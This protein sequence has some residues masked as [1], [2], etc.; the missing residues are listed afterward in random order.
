MVAVSKAEARRRKRELAQKMPEL[1]PTKQKKKRGRARMGELDPRALNLGN[2]ARMAGKDPKSRRD[3][4]DMAH[5]SY[6]TEAG[7][8]IR[9]VIKDQQEAIKAAEAYTGM[10][11]A[12]ER[13]MTRVIGAVPHAKGSKHEM[14]P[15]VLETMPGDSNDLRTAEEKDEAA[16]AAWMMWDAHIQSLSGVDRAAIGL[17]QSGKKLMDQGK[18]T[19][20]GHTFA[21]AAQA[22]AR[23]MEENA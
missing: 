22:L 3:R 18:P 14:M 5:Q 1:G 13:Y 4:E 7:C 12:H 15:E 11:A 16:K 21:G 10:M 23:E 19:A 17:A 20:L 9:A 6:A 8:V 2:R